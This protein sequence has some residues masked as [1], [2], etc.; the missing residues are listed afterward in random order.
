MG[1]VDCW[2]DHWPIIY[3]YYRV[4]WGWGEL[5]VG[6]LLTASRSGVLSVALRP[7]D[8]QVVCVL[9]PLQYL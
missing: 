2:L 6:P 9:L 8:G 1:G 5:L 7:H 4:V 3:L